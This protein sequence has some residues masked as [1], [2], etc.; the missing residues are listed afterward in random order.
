MNFYLLISA[1]IIIVIGVVHSIVGEKLII[2][3]TLKLELPQIGG[4][5]LIAGRT[6]RFAWHLT[7]L[8]WWAIAAMLISFA[9]Q[10]LTPPAMIAVQIFSVAFFLSGITSLVIARGKHFSWY[11]FLT[12]SLL[13]WLGVKH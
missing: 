3:P 10:P 1:I 6:L 5:D 13:M 9:N 2:I 7:T 8:V 12:V 4:S 11:V